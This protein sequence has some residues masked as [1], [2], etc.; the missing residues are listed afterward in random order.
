MAWSMRGVGWVG[1]VEEIYGTIK[2]KE[3]QLVGEEGGGGGEQKR[4]VH[5]RREVVLLCPL[6]CSRSTSLEDG[7]WGTQ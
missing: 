6:M 4:D 5:G 3:K 1:L 2:E 7:D